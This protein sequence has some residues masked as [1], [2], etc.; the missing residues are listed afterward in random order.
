MIRKSG[1]RFFEKETARLRNPERRGGE[2]EASQ[3]R[4]HFT[5]MMRSAG[6]GAIGLLAWK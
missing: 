1:Y 6:A 3:Y 2:G 4:F 5:L